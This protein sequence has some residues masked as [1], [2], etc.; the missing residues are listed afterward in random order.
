M[1]KKEKKLYMHYGKKWDVYVY[2]KINICEQDTENIIKCHEKLYHH[3]CIAL[4]RETRK[5]KLF[6]CSYQKEI[7]KRFK[8]NRNINNSL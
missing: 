7:F 3:N 8:I 2:H 1:S 5:F 4:K 6:I